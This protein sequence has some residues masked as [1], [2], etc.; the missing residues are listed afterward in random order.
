MKTAVAVALLLFVACQVDG[1]PRRERRGLT[2][3]DLVRPGGG[4][5]T[6]TTTVAPKPQRP[7]GNSDGFNLEDALNPP[8]NGN[9]GGQQ[10]NVA[11]RLAE[12]TKKLEAMF[13][14]EN[15]QMRL[16]QA[17]NKKIK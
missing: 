12:I 8:N 15:L 17:I 9:G 3:Y 7:S 11:E 13:E 5:Q 14:I 4:R 1:R 6:T 2:I 16:L 10:T